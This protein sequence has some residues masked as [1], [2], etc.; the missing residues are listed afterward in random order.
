MIVGRS[1]TGV[2]GSNFIQA[3]ELAYTDIIM[4]KREGTQFDL[5]TS[6]NGNRTYEYNRPSG[7]I[8]FPSVFGDG[9]ESVFVVFKAGSSVP[10]P[11]PGV[12]VPVSISG[13]LL[14]GIVDVPYSRGLTLAGSQPFV[15]SDI[16]AP[17]GLTVSLSGSVVTVS[18]TPT[19][20]GSQ[21]VEFTVTNGCG[22]DTYS[23]NL[24]IVGAPTNFYVSNL[25]T[26]GI[27]IMTVTPDE[28]VIQTGSFPINYQTGITGAHGGFTAELVVDI[29][30]VVFSFTLGLYKN[31][32]LLQSF[33]VA[34]DG[35]YTF[36]EQTFLNTDQ[37][38]IVLN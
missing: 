26:A 13:S 29:E 32:S 18:G 24:I 3:P 4:V 8:I 1:Y 37:V 9:N 33:T 36:D 35:E 19:T 38:L 27:S 23:Q 16:T 31:G 22:T 2:A 20:Q 34:T 17:D 30:G 10:G 28:Y 15:L 12:C 21:L 7:K 6:G 11:I 25:S 14:K 5:Y